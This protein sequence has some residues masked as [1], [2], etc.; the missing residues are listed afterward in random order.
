MIVR[1]KYLLGGL[2][3]RGLSAAA[4][5][6]LKEGSKKFPKS[7]IKEGITKS[8]KTQAD[9]FRK[10]KIAEYAHNKLQKLGANIFK[11]DKIKT[12][13]HFGR[14]DKMGTKIVKDQNKLERMV[15]MLKNKNLKAQGRKPNFKGGL[16]KKP[17]LAKRGF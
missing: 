14:A 8:Q 13:G 11:G 15:D 16:I 7:V 6:F 3:A 4:K 2:V 1:K 9:T 17:K 10:A 12:K 5:K